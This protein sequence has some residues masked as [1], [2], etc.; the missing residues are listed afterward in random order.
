[1]DENNHIIARQKPLF[2][3]QI[4]FI[5]FVIAVFLLIKLS[6]LARNIEAYE[7]P[8]VSLIAILVFCLVGLVLVVAKDEFIFHF[9]NKIFNNNVKVFGFRIISVPKKLP[10]KIVL[11]HTVKRRMRWKRYFAAAIS[12]TTTITTYEIYLVTPDG[13]P[14]KLVSL[15]EDEAMEV[16]SEIARLYTVDWRFKDITKKVRADKK[17]SRC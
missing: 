17:V 15:K 16:S 1:M 2:P 9:D 8:I 7:L 5:G 3:N 14:R 4:R 11:V 12:F 13:K 10:E 6:D